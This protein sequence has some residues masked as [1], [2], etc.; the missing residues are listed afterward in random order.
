MG[1]RQNKSTERGVNR[2]SVFF[3][4]FPPSLPPSLFLTFASACRV[5]M[6]R[7]ET[8]CTFWTI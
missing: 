4:Y 2:R 7:C 8:L 3:P 6:E 1:S 5:S